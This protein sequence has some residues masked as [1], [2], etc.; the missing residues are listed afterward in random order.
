MEQTQWKQWKI[1]ALITLT[2]KANEHLSGILKN[3]PDSQGVLLSVKGGGCSGFS[4]V[5]SLIEEETKAAEKIPLET[6]SLFIDPLAIMFVTGTTID[7]REDIA[8]SILKIENPNAKSLCGCG[9]SFS[10]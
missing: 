2:S 7:Y 1:K 8:G 10:V 5:W 4:Y 3:S 9:E 6:G